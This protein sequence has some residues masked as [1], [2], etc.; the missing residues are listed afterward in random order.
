M[1]QVDCILGKANEAMFAEAAGSFKV[2]VV[3]DYNSWVIYVARATS[4]TPRHIVSRTST[5]NAFVD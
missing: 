1:V 4:T 5:G 3:L 2:D